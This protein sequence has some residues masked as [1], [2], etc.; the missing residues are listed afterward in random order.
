SWLPI[1]VPATVLAGLVQ[2]GQHADL[3][4]SDN[5]TGIAEAQF[6]VPWWYRTEFTL[7]PDY[8]GQRVWLHFDGINYRGALWVNGHPVATRDDMV[9]PFRH[10]EY[11]ITPWL[12][13]SGPN[14]LA[15]SV[16]HP[17]FGGD[18]TLTWVDWNPAPPDRGQGIWRDV[19]LTKSGPVALR[20]P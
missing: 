5:M 4:V 6:A 14:A 20:A 7:P 15:L 8:A 1:T 16:E 19:Y 18:L 11:D 13:A 17:D 12:A 3:Y 9:G 2:N 10:F